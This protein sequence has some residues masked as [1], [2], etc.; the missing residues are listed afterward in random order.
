MRRPLLG[1]ELDPSRAADRAADPRGWRLDDAARATL[2]GPRSRR[3][4]ARTSAAVSIPI[5]SAGSS[6]LARATSVRCASG[7]V[8]A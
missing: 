8:R 6:A 7:S 5:T 1:P 2:A 3:T 4:P